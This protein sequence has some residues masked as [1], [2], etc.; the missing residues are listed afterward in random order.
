MS[1]FQPPLIWNSS[2]SFVLHDTDTS[3]EYG[4]VLLYNVPWSAFVT[5]LLRIGFTYD[6]GRIQCTYFIGKYTEA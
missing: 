3:E 5:Y 6:L 4:S 2:S 1:S